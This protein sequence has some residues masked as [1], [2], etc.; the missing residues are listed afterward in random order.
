MTEHTDRAQAYTLEGFIGSMILLLA[1]LF[2]LQAV[3]ITPT[4]GG[5]ADRT[6]QA[7]LQQESSDAL[8]V[9][10]Q[11]GN[12]SETVRNWNA[13]HEEGPNFHNADEPSSPTQEISTYSPEE[14]ANQSR[15]GTILRDRYAN[16]GWNYNIELVYEDDGDSN[17]THMV[18]QGSPPSD[19]FTASRIVTLYEDDRVLEGDEKTLRDA[20]QDDYPIP[21]VHDDPG[22]HPVYNLVE[23]RVTVW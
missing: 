9:A 13:T 7:Q 2:A 3:V 23:L 14:F 8:A 15:L 10:S 17:S 6:V 21:P 18:Y 5:L 16:D 4:T 20:N 12:L 11:D 19:A 22:D 1:V